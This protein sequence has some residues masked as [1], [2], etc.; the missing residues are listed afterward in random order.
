MHAEILS[1]DYRNLWNEFVARRGTSPILQSY[2]WGKFKGSSGWESFVLVLREAGEIK[3]GISI[4]CKKMPL[5]LKMFYAPRGPVI[6]FENADLVKTLF[7]A[8]KQEAKKRGAVLLKIDPEVEEGE[9]GVV[10][11][12]NE[13]GFINN[14][15]QVQPRSTF[16]V[17]LTRDLDSILSSFEEKTRYNVRLAEK[18]G[19]QVKHESN[20]NGI[21]HFY[22]MYRE[23]GKRD[24]FMIHPKEYYFR[25]K[26]YLIDRD[27]AEIFVAYFRGVPVSSVVIFKFGK[28]IWYMYG[29]SVNIYRN[30]MPNHLLHWI[31]IKWAKE[32]GYADYDLW[33][34][35]V[36]P[37]EGHPL[38]GVYR[39]KKG[40]NGQ[41]L[42]WIGVYD[43]PFNKFLYWLIN[44]GFNFYKSLRS[45]ITKGKISDSL[46]E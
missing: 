10:N 17:D 30:V 19:V 29:A 14:K 40:F 31:V 38:Y 27:L 7:E 3:A 1:E 20:I 15:K 46:A 34:I 18:K 42:T 22:K 35:P 45:L 37:K 9:T 44:T 41:K 8:V 24:K 21:E 33:G 23:T 13:I 5:G 28:K 2:E 6:D 39:F 12:L 43:L 32:N 11:I 16:I 4:L 26:E 25:L 36:Y